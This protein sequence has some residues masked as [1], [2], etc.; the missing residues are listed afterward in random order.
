VI[1]TKE[2]TELSNTD[3]D[4]RIQEALNL[5]CAII[6]KSKIWYGDA[7][8]IG[9]IAHTDDNTIRFSDFH[10]ANDLLDMLYVPTENHVNEQV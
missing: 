7:N 3:I 4:I 2:E 1:F 10:V 8:F 6:D 5:S 9:G